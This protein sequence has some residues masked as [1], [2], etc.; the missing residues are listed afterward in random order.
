MINISQL[1]YDTPIKFG[2]SDISI[3]MLVLL[4]IALM[5]EIK[6]IHKHHGDYGNH[7]C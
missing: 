1:D 7:L 6:V 3:V 4:V 5:L 2:S